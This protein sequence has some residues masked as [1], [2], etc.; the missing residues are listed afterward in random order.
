[1]RR[2][3]GVVFR[4]FVVVAAIGLLSGCQDEQARAK[5]SKLEKDLEDLKSEVESL[6]GELKSTRTRQD[7]LKQQMTTRINERMDAIKDDVAKL[8]NTLMQKLTETNKATSQTLLGTLK[9]VREENAKRFK[10]VVA[11]DMAQQVQKI[12]DDIE[13]VRG[14]LIGFMDKQLRELYPYAYQPRR[15]DPK[16]PPKAPQE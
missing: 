3:P 11:V 14:E 7:A 9:D 15:M 5:S 6:K 8:Q 4:A 2:F 10:S 13:K 16:Q 1:M 12:R